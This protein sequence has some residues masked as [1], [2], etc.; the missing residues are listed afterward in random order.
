MEF[1]RSFS[2]LANTIQKDLLRIFHDY[3][4]CIARIK[5][6]KLLRLIQIILFI[7]KMPSLI[8]KEKIM[9]HVNIVEPKLQ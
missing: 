5:L 3:F 4:F 8:R 9:E 6:L 2:Y 1:S 7:T